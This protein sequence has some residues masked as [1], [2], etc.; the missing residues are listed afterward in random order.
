MAVCFVILEPGE[1][2][3][4]VN[5]KDS[6]LLSNDDRVPGKISEGYFNFVEYGVEE[7]SGRINYENVFGLA[8]KH[9]PKL[10]VAGTGS[11]PR[12]MDFVQLQEVAEEVGARLLVDMSHIVG[13]VAA[14]LHQNPIPYADFVTTTTAQT[15]RGPRGGMIMCRG[16]YASSIDSAVSAGVQ[17]DH[18]LPEIAAKEA[19]FREALS[20]EFKMYQE[21]T[22]KNAQVLA[23]GLKSYNFNLISGGTDNHMILVEL[24]NK[25]LTGKEAEKLLNKVGITVTQNSIPDDSG[26]ADIARGIRIG[27]SAVTGRG[28]K[29]EAMGEIAEIINVVIS[30]PKD[31]I[32]LANAG[33][34]AANLCSRYPLGQTEFEV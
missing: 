31:E 26:A 30:H 9:K 20:P 1:T 17:G 22:V 5:F 25:D 16:K 11:Y 33:K 18:S 4:G 24:L 13:L 32:L 29:D 7:G 2:V 3:L 28:M 34:L 15:L 8:F 14:G 6:G 21:Q 12:K 23:A 10:I 19:A 27:T